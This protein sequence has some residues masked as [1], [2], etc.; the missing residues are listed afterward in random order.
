M[1]VTEIIRQISALSNELERHYPGRHFTPDGHMLG[2]IGEVYA[3]ENYAL[4]L[5]EAS[6][7]KHDASDKDG[8][9]VQI[10]TTQRDRI[11]LSSM[12]EY[13]IVLRVDQSGLIEEIYNGP[14]RIP[15]EM[16]GK[17]QKN[18]YR[19][20][21]LSSLKSIRVQP[22]DRIKATSDL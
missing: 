5:Y 16:S 20:I 9:E 12:P 2:S 21:R 6:H 1:T 13:L 7:K 3:K 18:G 11:V 17:M 19:T 14:G 4:E 22:A 8:H 10:K 15:W